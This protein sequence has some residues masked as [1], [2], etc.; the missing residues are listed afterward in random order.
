MVQPYSQMHCPPLALAFVAYGR[1]LDVRSCTVKRLQHKMKCLLQRL[2][3]RNF[4]RADLFFGGDSF[5]CRAQ[6]TEV[7]ICVV[8]K[9]II[10]VVCCR[11]VVSYLCCLFFFEP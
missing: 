11:F 7:Y 3:Q 2:V 6:H 10:Y 9:A 8:L 4:K 5:A 1:V